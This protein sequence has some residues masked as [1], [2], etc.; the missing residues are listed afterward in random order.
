MHPLLS[1]LQMLDALTP[2]AGAGV[3]ASAE[4]STAE[5]PTLADFL[6]LTRVYSAV[7]ASLRAA[8]AAV[9]RCGG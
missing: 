6:Q 4:E 5:D 3:G 2:G 7:L 9:V 1:T 8:A